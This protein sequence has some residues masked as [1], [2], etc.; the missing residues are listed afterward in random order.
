MLSL[1]SSKGQLNSPVFK[2]MLTYWEA[3][4]QNQR[5]FRWACNIKLQVVP[6]K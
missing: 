4:G 2:A 1:P 5:F 6:V 3:T